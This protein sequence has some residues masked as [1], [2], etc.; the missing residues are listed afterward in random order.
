[1]TEDEWLNATDPE[2]MLEWLWNKPGNRKMRLFAAACCRQ[3]WNRI[4]HPTG[5]Q[6]VE[7]VE[8]F[9]EGKI[10]AEELANARQRHR[11]SGAWR[12]QKNAANAVS[13][14]CAIGSMDTA[15]L[16]S[17]AGAA[18]YAAH[19]YTE[20]PEGGATSY[21]DPSW[22]PLWDSARKAQVGLV[23]DIFGNPFRSVSLDL[24]W[25]TS[26]VKALGQA[27]YN[28]RAFEKMPILADSLED[29]GCDNQ[30]ILSHLRQPGK[31]CRGCWV[32]D[33]VLGKR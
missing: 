15:A 19:A 22:R 31:H 5:R 33:Q 20:K 2:P 4:N 11:S 12:V 21:R 25:L 30:D 10:T 6:A 17:A 7:L 24:A 27:I 18:K 1:M 32:V 16:V 29:A 9:A 26:T 23:L 14:A 28:D 8:Q 3:V 13:E